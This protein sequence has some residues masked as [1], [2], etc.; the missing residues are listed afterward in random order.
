MDLPALTGLCGEI[1]D[2]LIRT[3]AQNG[4]HLSSNL[5]VVE[6]TVAIHRAFDFS[7][8]RIVWDVGHQCYTHKL[9][10]G[11]EDG[12][13]ALRREG[14]I[15][16]FPRPCESSTDCFVTGHSSTSVSAAN[17]LAKAKTL[18]GQE[19]YVVAVIGDGALTGGLSYEGL[20][21]AGRSK[22]KLIIVLNDN[23]MSISRNVGFV[24]RHLAK[25]RARRKYIRLKRIFGNILNHIP[26]IGRR[27]YAWVENKKVQYKK[28][29]YRSST[30]FEE[31]G[32]YY[33]GP[34]DGHDL[35]GLD[36][37]FLT[38]KN[39]SR[40][41][42]LHVVTTKGKGYEYALKNPGAYHGVSGFDV[43]TGKTPAPASCF[44]S[45][46]GVA[47]EK[48]AAQDDRICAVTAAMKN[49][50]GLADFATSYPSRFFDVGIAEEHAVTFCSGLA[51]GG[52]RPVCAVYS[53][54][55]QRG[56]DQ[57]IND[58][59]LNGSHVVFAVDR[60]GIVPE[61]GETHQGIFDAAFLQTVP[62]M[63]VYAPAT[64][65]E[66][67]IH[68]K[69]ALYDVDGPVA[70]R[71]PKGIPLPM[72]EGFRGSY[73]PYTLLQAEGTHTL[74]VTYG[75]IFANVLAAAGILA[76]AGIPVSVLKLN[77]IKPIDEECISIALPY[78]RVIFFEEGIRTGGIGE[79]FGDQLVQRDYARTYQVCALD[80]VPGVCTVSSGLRNAGLDVE[81]ILRTVAPDRF[82][83][84]V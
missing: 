69:Q 27:L 15:S 2:T 68:L 57:L 78:R 19:G 7:E 29:M 35:K 46:F 65:E 73:K 33:L 59:S 17:G 52:M 63:T 22:D 48:L 11:R 21:N 66:L 44:S 81:G 75:R 71:Y 72:P 14:G 55:L 24:A 45:V 77:R 74:L 58:V 61:D 5:G 41:V 36:E 84:G 16:G 49:G 64:F 30:M 28:R 79:W 54:F 23:R 60:A 76:K 26:L 25:L 43:E 18:T 53:T 1:R 83:A 3:V 38:A 10:T 47:L 39:I 12:F 51:K 37:A 62:G 34:V 50:T 20:S 70:V 13:D 6:L 31:M 56:Y 8:D 4:G 32:F 67:E 42:V 9:L 82:E 80:R 40:P